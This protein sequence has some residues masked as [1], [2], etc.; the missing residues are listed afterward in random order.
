[1]YT[2]SLI[3]DVSTSFLFDAVIDI[4]YVVLI[5][6]SIVDAIKVIIRNDVLINDVIS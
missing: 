4:L 2:I 5:I 6:L 3:D 1:V